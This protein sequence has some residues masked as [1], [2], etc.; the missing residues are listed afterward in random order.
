MIIVGIDT[1]ITKTGVASYDS[2]TDMQRLA[3]VKSPAPKV[4]K[5]EKATL[6]QRAERLADVRTR[7]VIEAMALGRP[8]LVIIEAPMYSAREASASVHDRAGLWWLVV[9]TARAY[10][11]PVVEVPGPTRAKWAT[12]KGNANKDV[13][14][15][16]VIRRFTTW[17]VKS[18]DEADALALLSMGCEYVGLPLVPMPALN[19]SAMV[20]VRWPASITPTPASEGRLL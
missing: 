4:A 16:E 7:V 3:E 15:A 9:T 17:P 6:D 14:L 11:W 10:G 12:G 1:S 18:N 8:D 13:V 19:R 20:N 2:A 5:G